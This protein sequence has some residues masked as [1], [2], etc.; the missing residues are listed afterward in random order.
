MHHSSSVHCFHSWHQF[1]CSWFCSGVNVS[2]STWQLTL[3]LVYASQWDRVPN[4]HTVPVVGWQA[5][6]PWGY[7][8]LGTLAFISWVTGTFTSWVGPRCCGICMS[9]RSCGTYKCQCVMLHKTTIQFHANLQF[10]PYK[11]PSSFSNSVK[12]THKVSSMSLSHCYSENYL[13]I[14][15]FHLW[16]HHLQVPVLKCFALCKSIQ[17]N[18]LCWFSCVLKTVENLYLCLTLF[19]QKVYVLLKPKWELLQCF[20]WIYRMYG[21]GHWILAIYR[22]LGLRQQ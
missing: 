19:C 9:L 8:M 12:F 3:G 1:K 4:E 17:F 10:D 2:L 16:C 21:S 13:I 15:Y 22:N 11:T 20:I 6:I 18:A 14:T 5:H 7:V